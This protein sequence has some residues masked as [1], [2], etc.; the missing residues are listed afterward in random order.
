MLTVNPAMLLLRLI[1]APLAALLAPF[2]I[3]AFVF[4]VAAAAAAVIIA[5]GVAVCVGGPSSSNAPTARM[6]GDSGCKSPASPLSPP[7]PPP[8]PLLPRAALRC[9]FR[10]SRSCMCFWCCLRC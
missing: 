3:V 6:P 1:P 5:A 8:P 2:V 4:A 7:P 9:W 10:F